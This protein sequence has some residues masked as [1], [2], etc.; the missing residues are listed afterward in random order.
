MGK[1]KT[2]SYLLVIG[3]ILSTVSCLWA[4]RE[5]DE[6]AE[7]TFIQAH[8][9][10]GDVVDAAKKKGFGP[11][12]WW[13]LRQSFSSAPNPPEAPPPLIPA[14]GME[15]A[16]ERYVRTETT[17]AKKQEAL[18]WLNQGVEAK[19]PMKKA[20]NA[21]LRGADTLDVKLSRLNLLFGLK[22]S[23]EDKTEIVPGLLE[24]TEAPPDTPPD[25]PPFRVTLLNFMDAF[26]LSP[27]AKKLVSEKYGEIFRDRYYFDRSQESEGETFK[28]LDALYRFDPD[29]T[30]AKT[31]R[32][33]DSRLSNDRLSA[34]EFQLL[35]RLKGWDSQ[36]FEKK[37]SQLLE[38]K[39]L[40]LTELFNW[41]PKL[42]AL[43]A[44]SSM[45]ADHLLDM[46]C[47]TAH[48]QSAEIFKS[49]LS[50][51]K[52]VIKKHRKKI[53][54]HL[55]AYLTHQGQSVV[56]SVLSLFDK[57]IPRLTN[58]ATR[59][60]KVYFAGACA[61]AEEGL[62][63][64]LG[65][66][67]EKVST[68]R[69]ATFA[70]VHKDLFKAFDKTSFHEGVQVLWLNQ[71]ESKKEEQL[72]EQ[73]LAYF[74]ISRRKNLNP[75]PDADAKDT[76]SL[77]LYDALTSPSQN[78]KT[79]ARRFIVDAEST[80]LLQAIH[81]AVVALGP[82]AS[83]SDRQV[84]VPEKLKA[85]K[86]LFDAGT[87]TEKT[88]KS[89]KDNPQVG[90]LVAEVMEHSLKAMDQGL[91]SVERCAGINRLYVLHE[92][93]GDVIVPD[94]IQRD[95]N[96]VYRS[97]R[98]MTPKPTAYRVLDDSHFG[99]YALNPQGSTLYAFGGHPRYLSSSDKLVCDQVYAFDSDH[100]RALWIAKLGVS[101]GQEDNERQKGKRHRYLCETGDMVCAVAGSRASFIQK[102][103]GAIFAGIDLVK[104]DTPLDLKPW[105]DDKF[106]LTSGDVDNGYPRER[107][108]SVFS[109]LG[110]KV[111]DYPLEISNDHTLPLQDQEGP[112]VSQYS[113]ATGELRIRDLRA[114]DSAPQ[115]LQVF[116]A[117]I[118]S[119]GFDRGSVKSAIR[120]DLLFFVRVPEE[121]VYELVCFDLA[122]KQEVWSEKLKGKMHS[123]L[124]SS[125]G[126][127]V[128]AE[129][130][131]DLWAFSTAKS[132]SSDDDDMPSQL[133]QKFT[134]SSAKDSLFSELDDFEPCPANEHI[135]YGIVD[136][137]GEVNELNIKTG[138]KRFLFEAKHGRANRLFGFNAKGL[139]LI[140]S[141]HF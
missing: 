93:N 11:F 130:L 68:L 87:F 132:S 131:S 119:K 56:Y 127:Y 51:K 77:A 114:F 41:H 141:F 2:F 57:E 90:L 115:S 116:G 3:L 24:W 97:M 120:G 135:L 7:R 101:L 126:S 53:S 85:F 110:T 112:W 27:D 35:V 60:L 99:N 37:A 91:S 48:P 105:G 94:S 47:N 121:K 71:I 54:S 31:E 109:D 33:F 38:T 106:V 100:G 45:D 108:V 17:E 39:A 98:W 62:T 58:A 28:L 22:L 23:Q 118:D 49:F 136:S 30:I 95:L 32:L 78:R 67:L 66:F 10:Y 75:I 86:A 84:T 65:R 50:T 88:F 74:G 140:D 124:F 107:V 133:V 117:D 92:W 21:L 16:A 81:P 40:E 69:S 15:F 134:L 25:M 70:G 44:G 13:K 43:M 20:G 125:Q 111:G 102:D 79:R 76:L 8:P 6:A 42:A 137:T 138:E 104:E 96:E 14:Q 59:A 80:G 9:W 64:P 63:Y 82:L 12:S 29:D 73:I 4:G 5:E 139:P 52:S 61:A 46:G 72:G 55:G 34:R 83:L 18:G 26:D 36:I 113:Y 122:R 1:I 103:T 19:V 89:L 128:F 129:S 123:L